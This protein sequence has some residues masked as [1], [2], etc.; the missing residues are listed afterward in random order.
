MAKTGSASIEVSEHA[1][2]VIAE[3]GIRLET[4]VEVVKRYVTSQG[5][6]AGDISGAITTRLHA[7]GG[8]CVSVALQYQ[9]SME[10]NRQFVVITDC[11]IDELECTSELDEKPLPDETARHQELDVE[12]T[13][14]V[15]K[16]ISDTPSIRVRLGIVKRMRPMKFDIAEIDHG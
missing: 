3:Y 7:S 6:A 2:S 12:D 13:D 11:R 1:R 4:V 5:R 15:S 8:T 16:P 9:V 10:K 14:Y